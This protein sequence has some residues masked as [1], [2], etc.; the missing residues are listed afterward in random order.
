MQIPFVD[1]KA[2]YAS[3]KSEVDEAIQ[4]ILDTTRFIGG[5]PLASFEQD[6][7][8]YCDARHALGV[9]NGTDALNLALRAAGIG[10]GDEVITA[11][12][13]FI[14][15]AAA[16][17]MAGAKPVFVDIDLTTHTI[18]P[19]RFERAITSRTKAVIPI[20]LYGQP[21]DMDPIMDIAERHGLIVIE[22]AAQAH[23]AEYNGRRVGSIGHLACFSF[24]PG[25]NLGAY[26]DGGAITTNDDAYI[27][28][29]DKL[30]DHGRISK[31]EHAMVGYNS[32]LDSLQAAILEVKL[33]RLEEWNRQRQQVAAWYGEALADSDLI[34]PVIRDGSTHVF[35]LY[36]VMTEHR[37][38]LQ[39][40]FDAAGVATGIHYPLPLHLQPAFS[41]LGYQHGDM[42]NAEHAAERI[43]SLPIFPELTREQVHYV[44]EQVMA[45]VPA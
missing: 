33:R 24:Y 45:A 20:H 5:E 14:A 18:D 26:G 25:K 35:H 29:L 31:Y 22:D 3:I 2:Q 10:A 21:A 4:G 19:E 30:R 23:G 7:A 41:S 16:I 9:A 36:V 28:V 11:A 34:V 44:A 17:E 13:T 1:L 43:L 12:N 27:D 15:T 6:F 39:K 32:R 38:D 40:R 8:R 37:E 42:P